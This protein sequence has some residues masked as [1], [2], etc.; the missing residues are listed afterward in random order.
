MEMVRAAKGSRLQRN[1]TTQ[2]TEK[3]GVS[4]AKKSASEGSSACVLALTA[5]RTIF[6]GGHGQAPP[7]RTPLAELPVPQ[8]ASNRLDKHLIAEWLGE[9]LELD[10]EMPLADF[11]GHNRIRTE[12]GCPAQKE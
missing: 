5:P 12:K 11:R 3:R 9:K 7:A 10:P 2:N 6:M 4:T 8:Q 1:E